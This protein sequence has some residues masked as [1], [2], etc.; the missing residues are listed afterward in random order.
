ML[1]VD[2]KNV[3]IDIGSDIKASIHVSELS[4]EKIDDA[5]SFVKVNQEIEA[6][7]INI[8]RKNRSVSL[9]IKAKEEHDEREALDT[10]QTDS[11][12]KNTGATT[13]GELLK[14]KILKK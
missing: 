7:I 13:L 3:H 8:D 6:K 10:Y 11:S 9:S 12:S 5:R 1:E 2:E 14:E 4:L